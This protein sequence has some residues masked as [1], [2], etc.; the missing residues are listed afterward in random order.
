V[1]THRELTAGMDCASDFGLRSFV[2]AH[3]IEGN[4]REGGHRL[5]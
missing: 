1:N 5:S 3:R 4:V 2:R